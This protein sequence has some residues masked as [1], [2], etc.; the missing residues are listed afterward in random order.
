MCLF[1]DSLE[2][3]QAAMEVG[4]FAQNEDRPFGMFQSPNI[5][6]GVFGEFLLN[7]LHASTTF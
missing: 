3:G 4:S 6:M 1:A 5:I 7:F 2:K